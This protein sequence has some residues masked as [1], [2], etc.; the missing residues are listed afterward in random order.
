MVQKSGLCCV[1]T[2][3]KIPWYSG[4]HPRVSTLIQPSFQNTKNKN[5]NKN[6]NKKSNVFRAN[7]SKTMLSVRT[8]THFFFLLNFSSQILPDLADLGVSPCDS[9]SYFESCWTLNTFLLYSALTRIFKK[10]FRG[11]CSCL[12]KGNLHCPSIFFF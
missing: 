4:V 5:K 1:A 10:I 3:K 7:L 2:Q 11:K 12:H 9:Y 6:K 8:R